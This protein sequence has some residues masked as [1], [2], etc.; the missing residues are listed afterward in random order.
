[1]NWKSEVAIDSA[2]VRFHAKSK[3]VTCSLSVESNEATIK[4]HM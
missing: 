4:Y 2:G 3:L 1:M